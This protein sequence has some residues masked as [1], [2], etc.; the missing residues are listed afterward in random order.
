MMI[1]NWRT[2][3]NGFGNNIINMNN[4]RNKS[5]GNNNSDKNSIKLENNT[6]SII[7]NLNEMKDKLIEQ[8]E[9]LISSDMNSD[10]KKNSIKNINESI[11]NIEEQIQQIKFQEK[12]KEIEE[13]QEEMERKKSEKDIY[14]NNKDKDIDGVIVDES[15]NKL[16]KDNQSKDLIHGLKDIKNRE[17]IEAGYLVTD[18]NKNT[19]SSKRLEQIRKSR[20]RI[21]SNIASEIGKMNKPIEKG[22]EK[23]ENEDVEKVV[24]T[25]EKSEEIE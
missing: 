25:D 17:N 21:D 11:S 24:N 22:V 1:N 9:K 15:L 12:Q 13:K 6:N 23:K 16:I 4:N 10:L 3:N 18:D 14:K 5:E 2:I 8:K 19:F 20:V 7:K